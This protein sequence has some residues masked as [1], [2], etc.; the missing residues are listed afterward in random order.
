[1]HQIEGVGGGAG[2]SVLIENLFG[3]GADQGLTAEPPAMGLARLLQD[4]LD[5]EG[6]S[7]FQKY[8]IN[9]LDI[10]F[11]FRASSGP[12]RSSAWAQR[13]QSAELS[14]GGF[15]EDIEEILACQRRRITLGLRHSIDKMNQE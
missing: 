13:A 11:T 6:A 7:G 4:V 2:E 8:V 12:E 14:M 1:M 9:D 10:R 3:Q 15:F 5:M